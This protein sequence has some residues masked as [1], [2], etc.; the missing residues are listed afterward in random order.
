MGRA[1]LAVIVGCV[2][3]VLAILGIEATAHRLYPPPAGVDVS[4]PAAMDARIAQ[5]PAAGIALVVF[6]WMLGAGL[7]A[8][9]ATRLSRTGRRWPGLVVGALIFAGTAYNLVTIPHPVW[10]LA[11]G[12]IG[13]PLAAWV[14]ARAGSATPPPTTP[15]RAV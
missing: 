6:A 3:A 15:A 5:M 4:N 1:I 10:V 8:W 14:G 13:V 9:V 12:L 7:G 11:A 2:V